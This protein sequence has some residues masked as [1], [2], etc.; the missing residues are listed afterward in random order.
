MFS[1]SFAKRLLSGMS[2]TLGCMLMNAS[3]L[4]AQEGT[5]S[6]SKPTATGVEAEFKSATIDGTGLGWVTLGKDDFVRANCDEA[7]WTWN[8][9]SVHCTGKPV[10]V[11]RSAKKYKNLE[12]VGSWR[13]LTSGGNS[14]FFLWTPDEALENLVPGKL[15][16][17]GIEVQVLDHGYHEKYEKSTGKKGDWFT[18]NGDIFPVGKSKLIP[19][20][21]VSPA[22]SRSFPRANHS[23]GTPAWNHY[24]VRAINGEVRLW[25][26]GHEVSGGSDA[27]PAE[28]Y[29][30]LESEGAPI[31]F[32]DIRIRVLP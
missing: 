12:F 32:K 27:T 18:T 6:S 16:S 24:Y 26:N 14:G 21:P 7:T 2:L 28:G 5:S 22:G 17:A 9:S 11:L 13:H 15:P 29:L 31:D 4:I 20:P 1:Y 23:L 3:H 25:V 10:G 30:C 19:F 8:G